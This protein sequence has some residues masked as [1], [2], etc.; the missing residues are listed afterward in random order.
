MDDV[1]DDVVAVPL[2]PV[3]KAVVM[4]LIMV[5]TSMV[6]LD[7]TIANVALPHMRAA[8]GASPDSIAWVLTSYILA[9]AI[10]TPMTGWLAGRFG[11]KRLFASAVV[12]FTAS[13]ALCGIS[14]TLPMM[15]F[16]RIV[17]GM[18]G[19]FIMPMTQSF[20]YDMN[21]KAGQV[22]AMTIWGMG[23]MLS[24]IAGPI[25]GGY[26]TE[27][28]NWRWVFFI[29]VPIGIVTAFGI[30]AQMPEFPS[31]RRLFDRTGFIILLVALGSLQLM[32]DRGTQ[33][34]WFNSPEI[35]I[36]AGLS[37][38]GFW[39]LIHHLRYSAAPIIPMALFKDRNFVMSL[40][41]VFLIGA[42][43]T[44]GSTLLAPMLQSLFNYPV[45]TAGLVIVPRGLGMLVSMVAAGRLTRIMDARIILLAGMVLTATSL[46]MMTGFS[47]NMGQDLILW[48]G[49][50]QGAGMG[51]V[52][53]P[54]NLMSVLSLSPAMRT[55]GTSLFALCRS[56][57]GSVAIAVTSALLT[58]YIQINHA[59]LGA[60]LKMPFLTRGV[61]EG[62]GAR[63]TTMLAYANAEVTR[64]ATMIAYINDYWLMMWITILLMPLVLL[65]RTAPPVKGEPMHVM[66]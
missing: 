6:L 65:M 31:V 54:M 58:F 55:E 48:S 8:L 28:Y 37:L 61:V 20:L 19:A 32:L 36:E 39:M 46:W 63:G 40:L 3:R 41:L 30:T 13:S 60:E 47:V 43:L 27:S 34:D 1:M 10:S 49:L 9:S 42:I 44:A 66:E 52:S 23:I 64:Q 25:V 15:V 26:L 21:S 14:A 18:F 51:L 53:M 59:E 45:L 29:N 16:A 50:L 24:P 38:G 33:E 11:R 35:L 2:S 12:G 7:T 56:I 62:M 57:G 17:Q 5:T 4:V 22:R